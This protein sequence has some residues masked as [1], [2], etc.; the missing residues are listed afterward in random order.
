LFD[1]QCLGFVTLGVPGTDQD[2]QSVWYGHTHDTDV[3]RI[4]NSIAAMVLSCVDAARAGELTVVDGRLATH[5]GEG[6][7]GLEFSRFRLHR[8]PGTHVWPDPPEGTQLA[9]L[10][11]PNWPR[12]WLVSLGVDAESSS[13]RGATHTIA[14][15]VGMAAT[16]PPASGTIRGQVV[17]LV[18]VGD[19]WTATVEDSTGAL[20]VSC[21]PAVTVFTPA[22]SQH[23]EI[24]VVVTA[25]APPTYDL[26]DQDPAARR[27]MQRFLPDAPPAVATAVRP[28]P[29][30][31]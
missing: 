22:M 31:V 17:R 6:L 4:C 30:V 19:V 11:E 13:P 21:E 5:A 15:L 1:D 29:D 24:D 8:N 10:P 3:N 14:Q 18:A 9:R 23:V 7:D 26:S 16:S 20:A 2:D 28:L 25:A 12:P 27:V